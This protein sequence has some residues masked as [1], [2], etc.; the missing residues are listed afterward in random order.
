MK[1]QFLKEKPEGQ[2]ECNVFAY[3]P[4]ENYSTESNI[5]TCYSRI[6]QHSACHVD[7]TAECKEVNY[8]E[9]QDLLKELYSI[10]Y[11]NLEVIN[12]QL[13][14]CHRQPTEAEI[15]FGHGA[16]HYKM[17]TISEIGLNKKGEIKNW[18]NCK[19]DKL[20]YNTK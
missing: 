6:G 20:R 12:K 9:Y 15:K 3:F 17:F 4:E 8:N 10:G 11:K 2:L 1:V 18:F 16:T 14:T 19:E 13:I 7:Y 5:K